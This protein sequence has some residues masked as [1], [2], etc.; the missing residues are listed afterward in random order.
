V[1]DEAFGDD[2]RVSVL[3]HD[4]NLGVGGAVVTGYRQALADHNDIVVKVDGDG[5]MDAEQIST[6]IAPIVNGRA[7]YT[8]GNR[9]FAI[10]YLKG[11]PLTRLLGNSGLSFVNKV[12]SGYWNVMDPTN[13][14]TAIHAEVL[15][16]LPLDRLA[17]RYFFESDMLFRLGTIRAVVRD[18]PIPA[19]YGQEVSSLH[20]GRA[21]LDFPLR[22]I[23]VFVKR[24][25]Y[26]YLLR[27]LNVGTIDTIA[28]IILLLFGTI[29]GA[30]N[31]ID[32]L[33][34][35]RLTPSGTVMLAAISII[36]GVQF[37]LAAVSFD[38]ANVPSEPLHRWLDRKS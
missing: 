29:F 25:A 36:L 7:D 5:Q 28:G 27:D 2:S 23:G 6:L 30:T 1:V 21:L 22:Y 26:C 12:A 14:F 33:A 37:L 15:K 8:K 18:V 17:Q 20:V 9:F 11:M 19:K 3:Y 35:G 34:T 32:A 10:D 13:G 4:V 24:F 16:W 38:I 31:W